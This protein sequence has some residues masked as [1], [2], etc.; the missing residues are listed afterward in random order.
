RLARARGRQRSGGL[1]DALLPEGR[2]PQDAQARSDLLW[3]D[4]GLS[5]RPR[6]AVPLPAVLQPPL[7]QASGAAARV[8]VP[9]VSV[10][11]S[12]YN[13]APWVRDAVT[14]VLAQELTD[15]EL[16]V[17]DDGSSDATP[18]VLASI[19]DPRLRLERRARQGLTR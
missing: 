16:I 11:M 7:S 13:G 12:V 18:D 6:D 9:A 3:S 10:L 4:Q 14:S 17:I 8:S 15:L 19:H 5:P 1:R 2:R